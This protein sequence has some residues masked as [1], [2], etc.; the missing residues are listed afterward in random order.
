MFGPVPMHVL[1]VFV[2]LS[3]IV[4]GPWGGDNLDGHQ[5]LDN[6]RQKQ[7]EHRRG[8]LVQGHYNDCPKDIPRH[9]L[10]LIH[11]H[12]CLFIFVNIATIILAEAKG[13]QAKLSKPDDKGAVSFQS[14]VTPMTSDEDGNRPGPRWLLAPPVDEDTPWLNCSK[15]LDRDTCHARSLPKRSNTGVFCR[16]VLRVD[17]AAPTFEPQ[18]RLD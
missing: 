17:V 13:V 4:V 14:A 8:D 10:L 16:H 1:I 3:R 5:Y 18:A 2:G 9:V 15:R 7:R 11:L 12:F 6:P